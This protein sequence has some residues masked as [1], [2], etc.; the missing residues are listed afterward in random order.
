M[1]NWNTRINDTIKSIEQSNLEELDYFK[2]C[3]EQRARILAVI[4][5]KK[6]RNEIYGKSRN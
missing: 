5:K 6:V 1:I 4:G 3:I 2:K